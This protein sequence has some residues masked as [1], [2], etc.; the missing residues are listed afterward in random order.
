MNIEWIDISKIE[1]YWRNPRKNDEAVSSVKQ[2]I[3][4]FGFVNPMVIDKDNVIVMGHTRYR[5][6]NELKGTLETDG[7]NKELEEN[8]IKVNNGLVPVLQ[9]TELS[10]EKVKELRIVDNKTSEFAEWDNEKL[11]FELRELDSCIGFTPEDIQKLHKIDTTFG[12]ITQEEIEDVKEDVESSVL[13]TDKEYHEMICPYCGEEYTIT[14]KD[15]KKML[16]GEI[17]S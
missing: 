7:F 16:K 13:G 2:S 14:T 6:V 12:D 5:A 10:D 9:V 3:K 17:T 4:K 11:I 1:P 15:I 8:L